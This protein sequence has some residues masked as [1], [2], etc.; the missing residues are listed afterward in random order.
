[1]LAAILADLGQVPGLQPVT[2]LHEDCSLGV[3]AEVVRQPDLKGE[4]ER[5]CRL[6]A[7][8]DFTLAIAPEF[9]DLLLHRTRW[10]SE[11]GGRSLG[12]DA[13]AV[14]LAG[15]K[16]ALASH[17]N[18]R[19]IPTPPCHLLPSLPPDLPFP[20]VCKPRH[21]AG[22]LA[23]SL[24]HGP[25]D[26]TACLARARREG[27]EGE[28]LV[29][30]YV[31]GTAASVAFL[32]GPGQC[33]SLL[34]AAQVLSTDGRFHYQGGRIPLG[35]DMA[36]RA[37]RLAERALASAPGLRGYVG[38]DLVL[39]E[40][41]GKDVVIEI[42]PR[43]TT[44]YLGLRKLAHV[45]LA[46]LLLQLIQGRVVSQPQWRSATIRFDAGGTVLDDGA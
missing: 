23:T 36:N 22:S 11:A 18:E 14:G 28:F 38:V 17:L 34:P 20:L 6:A 21:G 26:L 43:L 46:G 8:C 33:V 30:P 4:R 39:G 16:L 24:V 42:N 9:E 44:S 41:A 31:P 40:E 37:A 45:N 19:G 2:L 10:V 27:Y 5:F 35:V 13:E 1:M 7:A 15:D 12:C 25:G 29:Q 32:I 3:A